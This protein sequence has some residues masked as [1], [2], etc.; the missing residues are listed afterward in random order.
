MDEIRHEIIKGQLR[1]LEY[2]EWSDEMLENAAASV[3]CWLEDTKPLHDKEVVGYE[4]IQEND[5]NKICHSIYERV[6][7]ENQ[8]CLFL[9]DTET[10]I[11]A[12]FCVHNFGAAIH[13]W[14]D[15]I[16]DY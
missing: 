5:G 16:I 9:E 4:F 13:G 10:S 14:F 12:I 3:I 1:N 8:L 2:Y 6:V 15:C 11:E 7:E